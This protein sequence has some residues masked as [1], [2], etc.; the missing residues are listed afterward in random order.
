[1][2]VPARWL[3]ANVNPCTGLPK[4]NV[5]VLGKVVLQH[6]PP[7]KILQ[8]VRFSGTVTFMRW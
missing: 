2:L 8:E 4:Q 1:M 5:C 7:D 6:Q 3:S